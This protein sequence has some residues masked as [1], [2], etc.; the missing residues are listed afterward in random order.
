M[1]ELKFKMQAD[2]DK[3]IEECAKLRA[4]RALRAS[5]VLREIT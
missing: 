2:F 3:E 5:P 1:K 4:S